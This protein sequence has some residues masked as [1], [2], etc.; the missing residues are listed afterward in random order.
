MQASVKEVLYT[1]EVGIHPR[2]PQHRGNPASQLHQ[3]LEGST[4]DKRAG[5]LG[6]LSLLLVGQTSDSSFA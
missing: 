5:T 3:T 4:S 6:A 2:R 1:K